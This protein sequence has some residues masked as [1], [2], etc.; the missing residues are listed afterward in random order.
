MLWSVPPS[1]STRRIY[2]RKYFHDSVEV[3]PD[4]DTDTDPGPDTGPDPGTNPD[5]N[6]EP[7]PDPNLQLN[8]N[9]TLNSN[10]N[11]GTATAFSFPLSSF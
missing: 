8:L 7:N 5:P 3:K 9:P 10:P 6:L 1:D 2:G 11:T 4:P